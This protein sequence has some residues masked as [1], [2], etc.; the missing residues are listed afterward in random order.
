M[1][2]PVIDEHGTKRWYNSD[3]KLHRLD[4]PAVEHVYGNKCWFNNGKLHRLDGP[5]V[6]WADGD[7]SWWIY[8]IK[9]VFEEWLELI[10]NKFVYLSFY[11]QKTYYLK[12]IG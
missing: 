9:Y 11:H 4:G 7:K 5:A 6:E 2:N 1:S 8:D 12:I 3:G 10:P